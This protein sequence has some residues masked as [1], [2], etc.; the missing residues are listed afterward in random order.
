MTEETFHQP[1]VAGPG[2]EQNLAGDAAGGV[3]EGEGDHDNVV[4]RPDDRQELRDQVDRGQHPQ[5]GD[6]DRNL[7][8]HRH[9]RMCPQPAHRGD[10]RG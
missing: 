10:A 5:P 7:R 9:R 4:Q 3:P 2:V 1:R 8:P 6:P